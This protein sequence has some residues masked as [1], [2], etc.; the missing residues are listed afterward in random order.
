[1]AKITRRTFLASSTALALPTIVPSHVLGLQGTVAPSNQI[2]V[3]QIGF[4]WIGGSHLSAMLGRKDVRYVGACDVNGQ[5]L[6][7][8]CKRIG[9]KYAKD[10]G[11]SAYKAC[12][13]YGDFREMLARDD[14]DAVVIA[15]PDHWHAL[16]SIQAARAGKDIYCEKPLTLTIS[17]ART[18]VKTVRRYGR[19]FQTGSQQRSNVFGKFRDACE[20]VRN[21]RIGRVVS[22]DVSTGNS[23]IAC[24]LPAEPTPDHIDWDMWVGRTAWR[25]FHAK[26]ADKQWRPYREYCG[27]GF[28]DMG[29]HH[30]DIAQWALGMDE[31]GPIEILA[32]DG[33]QRERVSFRYANGIIM[34]HV[35]GN[36]LGLTFHGTDGELYVGRDGF[37]SKPESIASTP[38]GAR[39]M[40]LYR[41]DDHHGNWLDCIRTRRRC[42]A[43][44][45]IGA[46]S[47]TIC[48]LGNIAYELG[49]TL[50]WDPETER[51]TNNEQAN[52][53][54]SR[55]L[56]S[57]WSF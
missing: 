10:A 15:T 3:G 27:G 23:P 12:D 32:P 38:L 34:N 45:E 8:V 55:P 40:R 20:R 46:R 11:Q 33:N 50:K 53:L 25:P 48:H 54:L 14:M 57:P 47:A 29:A 4:G 24:D 13:A 36:C 18:V 7:A 28:A 35:G 19:V 56:R 2:T 22:V 39:E 26:L 9:E 37:W 16:L 41:S 31:T 49:E 6:E 17:E 5:T 1:M 52:R 51:F 21:G 42:V 30:F 44:V 43:D